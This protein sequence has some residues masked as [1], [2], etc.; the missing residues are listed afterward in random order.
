[1]K[2]SDLAI[3]VKGVVEGDGN[4]NI[5]GLSG[6]GAA[7]RSD[8]TFAMDEDK[9][10]IAEQSQTGCVL[11]TNT[12]RKSTKNLIRVANPK[13][14][15]L[16]LYNVLYKPT[17]KPAFVHPSAV[18]ANSVTFGNNVWVD[19]HVT[20]EENVI[21]SDYTIIESG[22]VIKRN[23]F[24]GSSCHLYPRVVLYENTVL[25]DNVILHAGVVVGSDGFGYVKDK[26]IIY[27]FPQ[28]GKVI[29]ED[30]V[31]IGANCTIDRG[32]LDDTIIGSNS[33][34]DNLCHI[35]HNV[36]IGKNVIMAAQCGVAGSTVIE[37][38]VTMS[39]QIAVTDNVRVG[40]NVV[41]GGKSA[42]IGNIEDNAVVWGSPARP[43]AQTKR[44]MAVLSWLTKNF[45]SLSKIVKET[46]PLEN[47]QNRVKINFSSQNDAS[48][49]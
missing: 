35:A 39:G 18:V 27:K 25:K 48:E 28:L 10:T 46:M 47:K 34:L 22:A 41:I 13:F 30:N 3:L 37:D 6:S 33:K 5:T 17:L 45:S 4:V 38:N 15:F 12:V 14:A 31:E 40:K 1:M 43:L 23:C 7:K 32:S 11:T 2:I 49:V 21:I 26:D 44:Q 19:S 29:I 36:K 42:V 24:I 20:I 16:I 9:L 8:L